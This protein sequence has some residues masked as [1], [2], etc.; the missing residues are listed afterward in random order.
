MSRQKKGN[1]LEINGK[2]FVFKDSDIKLFCKLENAID[3]LG[4]TLQKSGKIPDSERKTVLNDMTKRCLSVMILLNNILSSTLDVK[5]HSVRRVI[6]TSQATDQSLLA[7]LNTAAST[8]RT[9]TWLSQEIMSAYGR[10]S[11]CHV[12]VMRRLNGAIISALR[13]TVHTLEERRG[14]VENLGDYLVE[15]AIF[16]LQ[17]EENI[18]TLLENSDLLR[19]EEHQVSQL[20]QLLK[21]TKILLKWKRPQD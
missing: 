5:C 6:N 4:R 9:Q 13:K 18:E 21:R 19:L 10:L 14:E 12:K 7:A 3:N 17:I 16:S 15:I 1:T 8:G 20:G 2:P 11:L